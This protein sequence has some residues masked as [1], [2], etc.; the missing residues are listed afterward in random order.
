MTINFIPPSCKECGKG[1]DYLIININK[2]TGQVVLE[3]I[4]CKNWEFKD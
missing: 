3:C 1:S 2:V 4:D